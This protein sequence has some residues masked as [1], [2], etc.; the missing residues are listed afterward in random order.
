MTSQGHLSIA[1]RGSGMLGIDILII[2][3]IALSAIISLIRGF[4]Q[5]AL[6]LATWI[7]AF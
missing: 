7:A 1:R 3:I 4:V 6:S 2:A 5:E